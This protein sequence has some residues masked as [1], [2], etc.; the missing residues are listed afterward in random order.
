[1]SAAADLRSRTLLL[2]VAGS[3]AYGVHRPDSDV[4]LKGAAVGTPATYHGIGKPFEQAEGDAMAAFADLL[5]PV[6][7][8]ASAHTKLEGTVYEV[9]KLLRLA[10]DSNPNILEVLFCREEEVRLCTPGGRRLRDA[11]DL[12]LTAR[13]KHTFCGYAAAQL[14]R[15]RGH[16]KWLLDPPTHAPTRAEFGLPEH[17]LLPA[18]QLAAARAAVQR[19]ADGWELDLGAL[20]DAEKL[21]VQ[22]R[23]GEVL[24]EVTALLGYPSVDDGKFVAA[25][26]GIGLDDNL[27][28]VMQRERAYEAAA[29]HWRQY[30]GWRNSRNPAR[31]ALEAKFGFD[32]KHA[33][34][35]VRLL[36]MGREIL[37]TGRVHVWRGSDG[38]AGDADEIRAIREGAWSYDEL[39]GWAEAEDAELARIYRE[40]RY[41]VP[42]APDRAAIDALCV[43]VVEDALAAQRGG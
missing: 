20:G 9:R 27:I 8:A 23:V 28:L 21:D 30:D 17:T 2:V 36:R 41:V 32:A 35:L 10:A 25:A 13:A 22:E 1:L 24:T 42:A 39:V 12:F 7:Q 11:R 15:I 19:K 37:T 26:R 38:G 3:R 6:E 40:K 16:R 5:T 31:A 4:D 29:R 18:D 33:G 43:S 34:H 14:K